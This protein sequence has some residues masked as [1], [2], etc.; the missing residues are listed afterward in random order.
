[1]NG[2]RFT[3]LIGL[4]GP[5]AILLLVLGDD[6][7]AGEPPGFTDSRADVARYLSNHGDVAQWLGHGLGALAIALLLVFYATLADRT[8]FPTQTRLFAA[9]AAAIAI[10]SYAPT[11]VVAGDDSLTVANDKVLFDLA[12]GMFTISFLAFGLVV[13]AFAGAPQL[14]RLLSWSA[15]VVGVGLLVGA[16]AGPFWEQAFAVILLWFAWVIAA[17][18][19]L[20]V[21]GETAVRVEEAAVAES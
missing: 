7:I 14:P 9:V 17:G 19:W 20:V 3:R 1:M 12:H 6:G 8:R 11:V 4:A 18:A 10:G 2:L 16:G 13:L 5:A 21:R 15:L